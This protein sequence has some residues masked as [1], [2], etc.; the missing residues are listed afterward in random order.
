VGRQ[1]AAAVRE[2]PV[3]PARRR[4]RRQPLQ[5]RRRRRRVATGARGYDCQ[6]VARQTAVKAKY[7]LSVTAAERTAMASVL[8]GCPSTPVPTASVPPLG[9]FPEY[10]PPAP[11]QPARSPPPSA[12]TPPPERGP[13]PAPQ[14]STPAPVQGVHSGAFCSPTGALGTTSAGTPIVCRPSATDSRS[15]WRSAIAPAGRRRLLARPLGAVLSSRLARRRTGSWCAWAVLRS[16]RAR[17]MAA[18][19]G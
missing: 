6:Y 11:S 18:D 3:E 2:R 4:R 1:H 17:G 12:S 13:A 10:S 9:G 5:G 19:Y 8:T 14:P 7:H 16:R 15:R